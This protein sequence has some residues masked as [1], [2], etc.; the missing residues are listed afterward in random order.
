MEHLHLAVGL[1]M[2]GERSNLSPSI[3]RSVLGYLTYW[4]M[5]MPEACKYERN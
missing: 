4:L 3:F 2:E 1:I 5:S